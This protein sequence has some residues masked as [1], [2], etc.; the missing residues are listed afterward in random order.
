[1]KTSKLI[2]SVSALRELGEMAIPKKIAVKIRKLLIRLQPEMDEFNKR[3][4]D[5]MIEY[6]EE[7]DE[8]PGYKFPD[9]KKYKTFMDK[10]LELLDEEVDDFA[11]PEIKQSKLLEKVDL[12]KPSILFKL[13]WLIIDDEEDEEAPVDATESSQE[14]AA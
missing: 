1:M 9:K 10:R 5:L 13:D 7:N 8:G 12:I 6:G 2:D 4:K 14:A 11:V 3:E